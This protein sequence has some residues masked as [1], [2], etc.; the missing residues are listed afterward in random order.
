MV[1]KRTVMVLGAGASHPYGFP[2][3]GTLRKT[4]IASLGPNES[5]SLKSSLRGLGYGIATIERFSQELR[6]AQHYSVDAFLE[7]R[8][9]FIE[10]GKA[11]IAAALIPEEDPGSLFGEKSADEWY[12][13]LINKI[14]SPSEGKTAPLTILTFNYDRSLEYYIE[15]VKQTRCKEHQEILAEK[16]DKLKIIH[17]HGHLGLLPHQ[18]TDK[19]EACRKYESSLTPEAIKT[20]AAN[21]RII[22]ENL[23]ND[24]QFETAREALSQAQTICF[25][26][27][28][29]H[30]VNIKR[31]HPQTWLPK[32]DR[33]LATVLGLSSV[34]VADASQLFSGSRSFIS[35]KYTCLEILQSVSIL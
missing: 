10:L 24:Y 15:H 16:L 7:E 21:I 35:Y 32:A 33:I 18:A 2:L 3:G 25:M 11:A 4:I 26:G 23:D 31:L 17:L 34:D 13:Y 28:S 8:P 22:H 19:N 5:N 6:D 9:E 1:S 29:Y 30:P 20:A 12:K 27:M 14:W